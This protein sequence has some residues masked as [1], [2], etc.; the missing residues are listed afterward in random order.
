MEFTQAK[1]YE[2]SR[3]ILGSLKEYSLPPEDEDRMERI[4]DCLTNMDWDG[5]KEIIQEVG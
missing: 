5:I 3:M 1:D 2:L 4:Q